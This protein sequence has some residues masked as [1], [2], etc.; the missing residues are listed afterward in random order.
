MEDGCS[1][2]FDIET[3]DFRPQTFGHSDPN[4]LKSLLTRPGADQSR[5]ASYNS[6]HYTPPPSALTSQSHESPLTSSAGGFLPR[7]DYMTGEQHHQP[8]WS[9]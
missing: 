4:S 9:N 8:L 2:R 6:S 7:N 1:K 5:Q 3:V